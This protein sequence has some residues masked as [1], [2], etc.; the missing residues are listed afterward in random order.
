MCLAS[1]GDYVAVHGSPPQNLGHAPINSKAAE[2]ME[3]LVLQ[4]IKSFAEFTLLVAI[5]YPRV[6]K[7]VREICVKPTTISGF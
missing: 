3:T 5:L 1:I 6:I 7:R 4:I 2:F